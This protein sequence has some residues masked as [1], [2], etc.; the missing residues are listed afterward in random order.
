MV[1]YLSRVDR[2]ANS[3]VISFPK[4]WVAPSSGILHKKIPREASARMAKVLI[5]FQELTGWAKLGVRWNCI[6]RKF[7]RGQGE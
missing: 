1:A 5:L 4:R 7:E 3:E 2:T 6:G